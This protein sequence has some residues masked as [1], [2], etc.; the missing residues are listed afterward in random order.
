[1][2]I[3]LLHFSTSPKSDSFSRSDTSTCQEN[4]SSLIWTP[5][6]IG[7]FGFQCGLASELP[8]FRTDLH[9]SGAAGPD[10]PGNEPG[11]PVPA[12]PLHRNTAGAASLIPEACPVCL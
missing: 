1:L 9:K 3:A 10:G 5:M 6:I 4:S 7:L 11:S 2:R 12:E 8:F